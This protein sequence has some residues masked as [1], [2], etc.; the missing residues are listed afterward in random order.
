MSDGPRIAI[1]C[2]MF[3]QFV[4]HETVEGILLTTEVDGQ[5]TNQ[6]LLEPGNLAALRRYIERLAEAQAQR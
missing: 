1:G 2:H 4:E 6:I 3:A 5:V